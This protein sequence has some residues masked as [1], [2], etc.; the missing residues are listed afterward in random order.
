MQQK[1][2]VG[3]PAEAGVIRVHDE[4]VHPV[5]LH[6]ARLHPVRF[7][8]GGERT[9]GHALGP[10]QHSL[11]GFVSRRPG[12]R[13]TDTFV[14]LLRRAHEGTDRNSLRTPDQNDGD[15]SA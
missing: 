9:R 6:P 10:A 11:L 13:A 12:Y 5:C 4:C 7:P 15:I 1:R 8:T 3:T 2:Q 14:H